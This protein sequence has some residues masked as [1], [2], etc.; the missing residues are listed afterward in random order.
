MI[1]VHAS[2]GSD[3]YLVHR[4]GLADNTDHNLNLLPPRSVHPPYPASFHNL[5]NR[6]IGYSVMKLLVPIHTRK[7]KHPLTSPTYRHHLH[8]LDSRSQR[9]LA[10]PSHIRRSLPIHHLLFPPRI[11]S[12]ILGMG[13]RRHRTLGD[14]LFGRETG[15]GLAGEGRGGVV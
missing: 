8:S 3:Q 1:G 5:L 6:T 4:H 9:P 12:S 10:I 13:V 7:A 14:R 2:S 11:R 15:Q